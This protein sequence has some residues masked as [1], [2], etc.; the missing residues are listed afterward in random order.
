MVGYV[1]QGHSRVAQG[2]GY[3][4]GSRMQRLAD[5][6][7]QLSHKSEGALVLYVTAGD[8]DLSQLPEILKAL[9]EGGADAIEIGIPYSD[10]IADGPTIQASSQRALDRGV[11]PKAIYE[12]LKGLD[13]GIPIVAMGYANTFYRR[14]YEETAND[15]LNAGVSAVILCDMTPDEAKDWVEVARAKELDTVFLAAPTSTNERLGVVARASTGFIYAV[16]RTGVTGA[17]STVPAEIGNLVG[18]LK[19]ESNLPVCVGFGVSRPEHVAAVC[20]VADGA[21]IGSAL[22]T[23][24]AE[25]WQGGAG[26]AAIIERVR[27]WKAATKK[28]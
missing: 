22:V 5:K 24:L 17:E 6:F 11:T 27:E 9:V 13:L 19:A 21:V 4:N 12:A 10:P 1:G 8:P 23:L 16:S 2:G 25:K 20:Q 7:V 18:A 15:L 26:R 28:A 14:G 3:S